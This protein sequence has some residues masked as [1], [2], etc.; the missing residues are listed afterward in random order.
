M[1]ATAEIAAGESIWAATVKRPSFPA[2]KKNMSADVCVVGAGIAG[3]TSAYLL[4][5]AGKSVILLD[6]GPLAGGMT[7]VT[8]AHLTNVIDDRYFEI[9]RLHGSEGARLAAH[10][11]TAAINRIE[12]IVR[13]EKIECEFERVD[14]Y[15]FLPPGES[16]DLLD[17]ELAAVKRAGLTD[18]R[19]VGRAPWK[20][21]DSGPCLR[22]THQGQ[23]HPLKYLSGLAEAIQRLGGRIYTN[24]HVDRI[25]G[26][27]PAR[28]RAAGHQVSAGAVVVAT[29]TPINDL[30]A[31]H[32]KQAPYMTYVIGAR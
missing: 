11:H 5:R 12:A 30:V 14:G 31:I 29:N 10:S 2:L 32:T 3:V 4:C 15:L 23:F 24:T 21:F 16:V 19:K 26:G 13:R 28:I 9:E 6:D 22:F 18:T 25:D 1:K 8:T 27:R 20:S 7:E 17:R